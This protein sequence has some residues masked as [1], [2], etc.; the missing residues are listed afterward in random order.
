[1]LSRPSFVSDEAIT[2]E[3][4]AHWL[5]EITGYARWFAAPHTG[6]E[7]DHTVLEGL[8]EALAADAE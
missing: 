7:D 3:V 4:A 8:Y 1:M 6:T 2:R 5:P